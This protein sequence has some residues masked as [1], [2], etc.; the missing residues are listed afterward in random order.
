LNRKIIFLNLALLALAGWLFWLL[1]LKWLE[2]HMHEHTVLSLSPQVR[3]R[4]QLPSPPLFK[5]PPASDYNEVAQKTLF[6]KDRNP[7]VIVEVKPPPPPPPPPPMPALPA[8]FGE[9]TWG[10]PVILLKLPKGAQKRYHAGETVGPFELVSFDAE[11]VIFGWNGKTVERKLEELKEKDPTP[12]AVAAAPAKAA[13]AA[14]AAT[15]S[16]KSIGANDKND[17]KVSDKLGIDEGSVRLCVAGDD[18]PAGTIVDGYKKK[19]VNG[20]MGASC[21][22]EQVNP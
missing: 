4:M 1:R 6:A 18:S 2:L 21:L 13:P 3:K 19:V 9:M 17:K 5:P 8:Y 14:A 10:D 22:W 15:P 16:V 11:K 7:N 20:L 12:D